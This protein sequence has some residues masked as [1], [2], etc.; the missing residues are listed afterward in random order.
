MLGS[1]GS[2]NVE[3]GICKIE[4]EAISLKGQSS[5]S[6]AGISWHLLVS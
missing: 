3:M 5:E 4:V 1:K 6:S 2:I